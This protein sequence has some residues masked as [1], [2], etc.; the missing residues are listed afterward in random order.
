[1]LEPDASDHAW[2][3]ENLLDYRETKTEKPRAFF[4]VLWFG[5]KKQWVSMDNLR[6]HDPYLVIR[7][8]HK[9]TIRQYLM[10]MDKG[11]W[12]TGQCLSEIGKSLCSVYEEKQ[13]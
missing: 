5:G 10:G 3:V 4:K 13:D 11:I 2:R 8:G 1:M 12:N 7:Y 6:M 9:K